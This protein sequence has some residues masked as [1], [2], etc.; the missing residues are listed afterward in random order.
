M[1]KYRNLYSCDIS[2]GEITLK[3]CPFCGAEINDAAFVCPDCGSDLMITVPFR[4]AVRPKVQEQAKKISGVIT[5]L[6]IA[7][8]ITFSI[9]CTVVFYMLLLKSF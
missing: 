4:V 9:T 7:S 3:N 8:F 5:F 2:P 6:I 1:L